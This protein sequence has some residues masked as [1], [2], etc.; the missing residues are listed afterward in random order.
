MGLKLL[1][2][3]SFSRIRKREVTLQKMQCRLDI[4]FTKNRNEWSILSAACV[5]AS[6]VNMFKNKIDIY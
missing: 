4:I 2:E 5:C 1:T 3:I 6:G